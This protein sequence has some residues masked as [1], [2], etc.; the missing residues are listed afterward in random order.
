MCIILKKLDLYTWIPSI[1]AFCTPRIWSSNFIAACILVIK[2]DCKANINRPK[3]IYSYH[4]L[5]YQIKVSK[6]FVA[7][8]TFYYCEVIKLNVI[9][10]PI[11]YARL[12]FLEIFIICDTVSWKRCNKTENVKK[13]HTFC[14]SLQ[15]FDNVLWHSYLPFWRLS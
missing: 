1:I 7:I 15:D 13:I 8:F 11:C 14:G 3:Y 10:L 4:L 6:L 12:L 5:I 2:W 9:Y